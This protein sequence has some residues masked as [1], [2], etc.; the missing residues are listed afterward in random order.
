MGVFASNDGD[1]AG[2]FALM[3][4]MLEE[5]GYTTS[6]WEDGS[7]KFEMDT[8][9]YSSI[10]DQWIADNVTAIW[11]NC[12]APH[13]KTLW[14]QAQGAG[15]EPRIIF[16]A[17]AGLFWTDME[18]LGSSAVGV[19]L[20]SWWHNA[21]DPVLCPG[22]GTTTPASLFARWE[23]DKSQPLNPNIGWGY[24]NVQILV[25]AILDANSLVGADIKDAL[26][27]GT[28]T[29]IAGPVDYDAA[30]QNC[31]VPLHYFQWFEDA[32]TT[33]RPGVVFSHHDFLVATDTAF[34]KT[35]P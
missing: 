30:D 5:A 31:P 10:Y 15:F 23:A 28:F 8:M 3:G 18:G 17:R 13:F 25:D 22:V 6:T 21:Y 14:T 32:T 16:A 24:A 1:G 4:A 35:Y 20:E 33:I 9:D 34:L 12:P 27:D 19:G 2:W 26:L 11:G 29:T 7:G